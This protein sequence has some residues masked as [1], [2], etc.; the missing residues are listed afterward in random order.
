[1]HSGPVKQCVLLSQDAGMG[2]HT[3]ARVMVLYAIL[4]CILVACMPLYGR[5]AQ[6]C[7]CLPLASL[8]SLPG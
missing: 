5:A 8:P 4:V 2:S 6:R 1:M 7:H 3:L